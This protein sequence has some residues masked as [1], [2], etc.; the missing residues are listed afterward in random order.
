MTVRTRAQL[1]A[2]HPPTSRV[3]G[4]HSRGL[5]DDGTMADHAETMH[6][7]YARLGSRV[8]SGGQG[9]D[10]G[11]QSITVYE[12]DLTK[13]A[14]LVG[15]IADHIAALDDKDLLTPADIKSYKLDGTAAVALTADGKTYMIALV[16]IVVSGAVELVAV[17]GDEANDGS[18]AEPTE[19]E[20]QAA[21]VAAGITGHEAWRG[22]VIINRAKIQRVA[23][24]TMAF[25]WE[26][27][28]DDGAVEE[29]AVGGMI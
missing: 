10:G 1:L 21:I 23:V 17:F 18:E 25:T 28:T 7:I 3:R 11:T 14:V 19:A 12:I 15:G 24:D 5:I 9:S 6:A 26:T 16:A 8:M 13:C 27:I 29:R 4:P 2:L 20:C 22:G